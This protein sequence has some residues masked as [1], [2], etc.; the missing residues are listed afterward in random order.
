MLASV[1]TTVNTVVWTWHLPWTTVTLCLS[2]SVDTFPASASRVPVLSCNTCTA[3]VV[4]QASIPDCTSWHS[5]NGLIDRLYLGLYY[6]YFSHGEIDKMC[7]KSL[8]SCDYFSPNFLRLCF[9]FSR[10]P[11]D[12]VVKSLKAE[13]QTRHRRGGLE[14]S[15]SAKGERKRDPHLGPRTENREEIELWWSGPE[16]RASWPMLLLLVNQFQHQSL[17]L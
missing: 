9:T 16:G 2:G 15:R 5:S 6:L 14:H 8:L 4:C 12:E 17:W 7:W 1:L 13:G 10:C 3:S 11:E